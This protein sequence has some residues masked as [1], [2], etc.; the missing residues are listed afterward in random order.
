MEVK[1]NILKS[2]V[3]MINII[4]N[5]NELK[6]YVINLDPKIGFYRDKDKRKNKLFDMVIQDNHTKQSFERCLR[7]CKVILILLFNTNR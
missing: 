7:A 6:K 4:S 2:I 5:D 1:P 3:N